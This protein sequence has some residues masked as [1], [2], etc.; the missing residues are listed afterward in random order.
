MTGILRELGECLALAVDAPD[1]SSYSQ[2]ERLRRLQRLHHRHYSRADVDTDPPEQDSFQLIKTHGLP[3]IL[4][5]FKTSGLGDVVAS[6]VGTGS[7]LPI[8]PEQL[9]NV[10]GGES[11]Q[12][13][14][15]KLVLPLD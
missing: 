15:A 6:W 5:K 9:Q 4:D 1:F 8:S 13:M 7:N 12:A 14:A 3:G 2:R 10:L 11:L